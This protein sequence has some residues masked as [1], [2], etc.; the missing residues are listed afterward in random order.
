MLKLIL[1][2]QDV[3]VLTPGLSEDGVERRTFVHMITN[4]LGLKEEA[5][6]FQKS[7]LTV[8]CSRSFCAT[9]LK[10]I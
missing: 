6:K 4:L 2:R 1:E 9:E 7:R 5:A 10:L 3:Q 8:N